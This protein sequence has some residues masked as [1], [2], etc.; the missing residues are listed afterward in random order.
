MERLLG[1]EQLKNA[2]RTAL[3]QDRLSHG[4]LICGPRGSGKHTLARLL[5]AAMECTDPEKRPCGVCAACRKVFAGVHP[6]VI[7]VDDPDHV[8]V[9]V[10]VIRAARSDVYVRPNEGRR[11]VYLFPRA[12]DMNPSAQNA[13]LKVL[14]EP[15]QY[16]AFLL[17][18]ETE[19]KLLETIRSRCVVLRLSPLPEQICVDALARE[20]PDS[21]TAALRSAWRR[22]GGF[23]GPAA[24]LLR[25]QTQ[26]DPRTLT[27]LQ[28]FAEKDRAGL[29]ELLVPME[30]LKRDQLLPLLEEW[31][32]RLSAA[33]RRRVGAETED[34]A[35]EAV[36]RQRTA[37]ELLQAVQRLRTAAE[38]CRGNVGVGTLCGALQVWLL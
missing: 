12:M 16:A 29:T 8:G 19:E 28:V 32:D 24:Q 15:P 36:A 33:L 4:Y 25:E 6:D 22:S 3:R 9:G 11:K 37:A 7:T 20:F 5:A 14:E 38:L 26:T 2:L 21:P 23:Y 30:K 10:D 18:A 13:L 35:L 1:N 31:A 17:L 27:F 34:L